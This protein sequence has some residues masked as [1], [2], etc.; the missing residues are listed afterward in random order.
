MRLGI[1][2]DVSSNWHFKAQMME[3]RTDLYLVA[4]QY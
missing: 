1:S 3:K 4:D 2:G